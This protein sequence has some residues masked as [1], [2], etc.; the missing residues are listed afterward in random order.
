[1]ESTKQAARRP[2]AAV[3]ERWLRLQLL[4]LGKALAGSCQLF[5]DFIV[6]TC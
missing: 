4:D 1:M 3:A 6:K 5:F 2:Q